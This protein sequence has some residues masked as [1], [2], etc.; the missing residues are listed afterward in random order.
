VNVRHDNYFE[1]EDRT[2][3]DQSQEEK[4]RVHLIIY[5][6]LYL[7]FLGFWGFGV[8]GFWGLGFRV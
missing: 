6:L 3:E 8:L 4:F 2:A 5:L 1:C 7:M